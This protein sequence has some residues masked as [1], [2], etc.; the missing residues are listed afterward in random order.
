M[1]MMVCRAQKQDE[2]EGLSSQRPGMYEKMAP[3]QE[4]VQASGF[5]R[6]RESHD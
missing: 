3:G 1:E 5:A 6:T 2:R 4:G